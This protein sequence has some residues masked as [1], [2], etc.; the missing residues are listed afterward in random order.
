MQF[1][2]EECF[3]YSDTLATAGLERVPRVGM[4]CTFCQGGGGG[5]GGGGEPGNEARPDHIVAKFSG[6]LVQPRWCPFT[7]GSG[8]YCT[9]D[10]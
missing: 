10:N 9:M 7:Q 4:C 2:R 1:T 8:M 3:R 6:H 5:G